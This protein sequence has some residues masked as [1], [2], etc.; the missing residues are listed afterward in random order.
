M[1]RNLVKALIMLCAY[2]SL[3]STAAETWSTI[4]TVKL[5]FPQAKRENVNHVHSEK[6]LAALDNM[7][8]L[9]SECTNRGYFYFEKTDTHFLSILLSAQATGSTVQ[10]AVTNTDIANGICRATMLASP[11]WN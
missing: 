2:I 11:R 5:I 10:I 9:P 3:P 8:W 1:K 7:D 6:I 4:E